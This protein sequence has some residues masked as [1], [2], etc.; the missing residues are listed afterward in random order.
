MMNIFKCG[1][2][3]IIVLI[4]V[5][6][7]GSTSTASI[8]TVATDTVTTARRHE[9]GGDCS[10]REREALEAGQSPPRRTSVAER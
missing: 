5:M 3:A 8:L 6:A 1:Q 10:S 2:R 4:L 9:E 7:R